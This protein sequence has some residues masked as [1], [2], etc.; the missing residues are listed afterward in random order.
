[1]SCEW[2]GGAGFAT[3]P[4]PDWVCNVPTAGSAGRC[5]RGQGY[6]F[7]ACGEHPVGEP[8]RR[9]DQ[10]AIERLRISSASGGQQTRLVNTVFALDPGCEP[11]RHGGESPGMPGVA[12]EGSPENPMS[13]AQRNPRLRRRRRPMSPPF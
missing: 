12:T 10:R 3:S 4:D 2:G 6:K 7:R 5:T 8:Y 13:A 9:A 11:A 1:M